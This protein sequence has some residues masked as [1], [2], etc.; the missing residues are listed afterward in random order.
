MKKS[1]KKSLA[2]VAVCAS[3]FAFGQDE[4][5]TGLKVDRKRDSLVAMIDK[6][7]GFGENLPEKVSWEEFVPVIGDQGNHG[8]CGG[9]SSGYYLASM[10]WAIQTNTNSR[11]LITLHAADPIHQ[12]QR[13]LE[14][15]SPECQDGTYLDDLCEVLVDE[16]PKRFWIDKTEC[17]ADEK[18]AEENSLIDYKSY[19]RLYDWWESWQENTKAICQSLADGHPV[20][21][22][23][24]LPRSFW[25]IKEDGL[26]RPTDWE[27]ENWDAG[28]GHA[29]TIVGYDDNKFGG[30]F[31]VVNSWGSDWGDDGFFWVKYEDFQIF[32]ISAYAFET[33]L[34][35]PDFVTFGNTNGGYGRMQV[36]KNGFFE[37]Y[38]SYDGKPVKGIYMNENQKKF[39]GGKGYMKKLVKRYGGRLIYTK[40]DRKTPIAAIIG[41]YDW[42]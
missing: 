34:K 30:A 41:G 7:A 1:I 14:A 31:R 33:E 6:P 13:A 24:M 29:M 36:K 37:G 16:G 23:M 4:H 11:T 27:K 26:L 35:R 18:H 15:P 28:G 5:G 21:M 20:L 39:F 42:I 2:L 38:F 3:T 19:S 8:T 17:E 22:G 9:W 40:Y 10:E 32:A 25:D 12:Y